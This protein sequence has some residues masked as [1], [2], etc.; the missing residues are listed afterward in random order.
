MDDQ[1][2]Q[3]LAQIECLTLLDT[4]EEDDGAEL[5]EFLKSFKIV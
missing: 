1:L 3:A 5:D 4:D 2:V